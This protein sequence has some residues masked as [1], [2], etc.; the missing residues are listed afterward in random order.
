MFLS[1]HGSLWILKNSTLSGVVGYLEKKAKE[2]RICQFSSALQTPSLNPKI[3]EKISLLNCK[4]IVLLLQHTRQTF[5][6]KT[7]FFILK[8]M[9]ETDQDLLLLLKLCLHE[10]GAKQSWQLL[11]KISPSL[12]GPRMRCGGKGDTNAINHS[13]RSSTNWKQMHF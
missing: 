10:V 13:E 12:N 11:C 3:P 2:T 6:N 8:L 9:N 1:F 7:L 5:Y 4:G